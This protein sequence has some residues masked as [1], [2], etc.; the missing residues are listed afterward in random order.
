MVVRNLSRSLMG[1]TAAVVMCASCTTESTLG[2][3]FM[4]LL[5]KPVTDLKTLARA[6]T[7]GCGP[8]R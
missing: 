6:C 8:H 3:L 5:T 1:L 7:L 4:K 2:Q